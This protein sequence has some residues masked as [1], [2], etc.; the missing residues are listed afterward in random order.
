M[1]IK[2]QVQLEPDQSPPLSLYLF[3]LPLFYLNNYIT[4]NKSSPGDEHEGGKMRND[5]IGGPFFYLRLNQAFQLE[6]F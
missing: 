2:G 5:I 6:S 3:S 4:L 1:L